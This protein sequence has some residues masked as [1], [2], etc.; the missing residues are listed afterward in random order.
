MLKKG[1]IWVSA[2][3]YIALGTIVIVV[4]LAAGLPV[5]NKLKDRNVVLQTKELMYTVDDTIRTVINEGP[6]S[7]RQLN[8]FVIKAGS[9]YVYKNSV[10]WSFETKAVVIEP[11]IEK[12][13]G[14]LDI[15]EEEAR[16][17]GFY[18]FN[19][20][21]D[22]LNVAELRL[23]SQYSNPFSGEYSL[24]VK[25]PGEFTKDDLPIIEIKIS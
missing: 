7:Q 18:N 13:E 23:N 10:N 4:L 8:P 19:L 25:N 22:Y 2:V 20:G 15:Y 21:A 24:Y 12:K 16:K 5:I 17:E 14:T 6:G 3:L 9:F 11:K 1:D